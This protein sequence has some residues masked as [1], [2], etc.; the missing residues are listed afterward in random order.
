LNIIEE[1][2]QQN[3]HIEPIYYFINKWFIINVKRR[4][5]WFNKVKHY[6][7][8]T[9]EQIRKYQADKQLFE[10]YRDSIYRLRNKEYLERYNNTVCLIEADYDH[11]DEFIVHASTDMDIDDNV[12]EEKALNNMNDLCLISDS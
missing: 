3:I 7:K 4:K 8:E 2:K 11:E 5:E 12:P 1:Y 9:I 10:D 6:F